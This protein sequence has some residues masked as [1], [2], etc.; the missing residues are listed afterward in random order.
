MPKVTRTRARR[1]RRYAH[2]SARQ[3]AAWAKLLKEHKAQ[4]EKKAKKSCQGKTKLD[5]KE[6][7][8]FLEELDLWLEWFVAD[9]EKVRTALCNLESLV[10]FGGQGDLLKAFCQGGPGGDPVPPEEPPS[11]G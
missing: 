3:K 11:W 9:Y 10:L 6:L 4:R 5:L 7:C 2:G 1:A 8:E